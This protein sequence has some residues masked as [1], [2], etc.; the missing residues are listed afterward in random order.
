[1]T[2]LYKATQDV[3]RS[4]KERNVAADELQS[5]YPAYFEKYVKRGDLAGKGAKAYKE[6]T[7]SLIA[8]AQAR[9][10]KDKMV[11][12]SSKMLELDNQRIG[13]LVKQVQEQRILDAAIEAREKG[14]DYT[15]N[16][17]AISIAA[18]EKKKKKRVSDAAKSAASY[19]EQN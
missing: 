6:L 3:S 1:M 16:G 9:A 18:Q 13:A 10:I 15:V 8:S 14:Y 4:M 12:N 11:E 5:K 19:A 2:L 7:N 17:V